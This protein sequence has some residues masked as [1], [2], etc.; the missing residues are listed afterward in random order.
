MKKESKR[1]LFVLCSLL[2]IAFLGAFCS[3]PIE[4]NSSLNDSLIEIS[5]TSDSIVDS[6]GIIESIV[7]LFD[8]LLCSGFDYPVGN[9][10]GKGEYSNIETGVKY[11]GWYKAVDFCEKYM[12]GIHPAEDWNGVGGGDTDLGQPVFAI[13]KGVVVEAENAGSNW[14]NSIVLEH[15]YYE[16][17]AVKK[18]R[19]LYIHL[20]SIMVRKG[21]VVARRE[22]I[23][24]LGNNYGMFPAHL[25]FEIRKES[26]FQDPIT[27]WPSGED[28]VVL[29]IVQ[30]H[31]EHPTNFINT[32]RII[33][34]PADDSIVAI[35]VK[36]DYR[37]Y[38]YSKGKLLKSLPIG[39][40]QNPKGHKVREG[41][42]RTPEGEYY[43]N[44]KKL[45][46]FSGTWG[47]F[48]GTAWIRIS[49]PNSYDAAL[50]LQKKMISVQDYNA[51]EKAITE[52]GIPPKKTALGGGIGIHG[53]AGIWDTL[54]KNDLTWGC[55]S[56]NNDQ[57]L[58]FY[59]AVPIYSRILILP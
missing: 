42:N 47:E 6:T 17:G 21:D 45:G 19:S 48:Y 10:D 8:T 34:N 32:H 1:R 41:D 52:K 39:L 15:R 38:I 40:G 2:G 13:G 43:L 25:H 54:Q 57:L 3:Q 56:I 33:L 49:Y 29:K 46:P 4:G 53:W 27:Y 23:G 11:N 35:A 36:H 59:N 51:I 12:Y 18:I 44:E 14:G 37:V 28:T 22:Q 26:V 31:F 5:D 9:A 55:I 58:E 7:H 50:G 16:N 20:D 30:K 24:T